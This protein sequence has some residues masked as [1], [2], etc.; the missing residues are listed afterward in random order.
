MPK[1]VIHLPEKREVF[2]FSDHLWCIVYRYLILL[3]RG[4]FSFFLFLFFFK[5]GFGRARLFPAE[6]QTVSVY[7]YVCFEIG[8]SLSGVYCFNKRSRPARFPVELIKELIAR[9]RVPTLF[10]L[11]LFAARRLREEKSN[12]KQHNNR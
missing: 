1:K 5:A 11:F 12:K 2:F 10:F 4:I 3:S 9:H 8:R 7:T 6:H